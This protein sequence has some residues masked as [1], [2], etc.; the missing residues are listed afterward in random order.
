MSF[1]H[2]GRPYDVTG[3]APHFWSQA[4]S[5]TYLLLAVHDNGWKVVNGSLVID[6]DD[7]EN[8]EQVK[9]SVR[10]LLRGC[11]C[12]SGC[13]TRRC[14]CCKAGRKCGPGCR[15]SNCQNV[16]SSTQ[17]SSTSQTET[18]DDVKQEELMDD[19]NVRQLHHDELVADDDDGEIVSD[20]D[21]ED[22]ECYPDDSDFDSEV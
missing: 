3:S 6:W 9:E 13:S 15:C 22:V 20:V 8:I 10:V 14:S 4:C 19:N 7:P 18:S 12:K 2:L 16:P 21:D 17:V 1:L 11:G 5:N